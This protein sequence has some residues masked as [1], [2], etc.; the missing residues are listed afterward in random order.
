MI[1]LGIVLMV[2]G[3]FFSTLLMQIGVAVLVIGVVLWILGVV[4]RPVG[5]RRYWY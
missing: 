1:A 3:Y 2:L 5:G 4:G